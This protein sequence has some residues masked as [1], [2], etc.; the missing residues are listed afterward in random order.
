LKNPKLE[1]DWLTFGVDV[2]EGD[3]MGADGAAAAFIDLFNVGWGL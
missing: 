3:L 1:G 2:L